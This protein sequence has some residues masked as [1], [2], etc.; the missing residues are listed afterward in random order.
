MVLATTPTGFIVTVCAVALLGA[1]AVGAPESPPEVDLRRIFT[2]FGL[3]LRLQGDRGTCS[4]FTMVG[5]IEY[6]RATQQRSGTILSVEF[7]NWASNDA[8]RQNA[9]GG[10]F[11][12]LW[13]GFARHGLCPEEDMAYQGGFDPRHRPTDAALDRARE[14]RQAG[15]RINWIKKWDVKTGLTD[16]QFLEIK[17][18]LA[19]RWPVC[20]GFRW[21][22]K[23]RWD[24]GVLRMT[25]PDA[26]VDGHSVLLVGYRDDAKLPGGGAFLI[27][28]SGGGVH[29]GAMPYEYV[30]AYMNDAAWI[31]HD[32]LP[33]TRPR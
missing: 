9:D 26:V 25:P 17:E 12:D 3:P 33:A 4:V 20:G 7:L 2:D 10:F 23:E 18:T 6:A 13:K 32:D 24:A 21:P 14:L 30:R 31:G 11:S 15:L 1:A 27:R 29:D 19:R 5:A 8:V 16:A 22:K 28:N